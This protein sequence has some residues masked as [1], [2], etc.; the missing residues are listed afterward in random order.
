[1]QLIEMA[2][3]ILLFTP[4]I[5]PVI[6]D[7]LSSIPLSLGPISKDVL[8]QLPCTRLGQ[9]L[10]HLHL[11]RHHEPA[12]VAIPFRPSDDLVWLQRGAIFHSDKC[13]RPLAP[14]RVRDGD[15][16]DFENGGVR[17]EHGFERD[18]RDVFAACGGI[19]R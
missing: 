16:A 10:H 8:L 4:Y 6:P 9:L 7:H 17:R 15:N 19:S 18:R 14:V 2:Y 5:T 12:D 3:F 1:M 11:P 13:F